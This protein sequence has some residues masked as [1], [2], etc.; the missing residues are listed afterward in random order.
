MVLFKQIKLGTTEEVKTVLL[1]ISS[2][3]PFLAWVVLCRF[4]NH[5]TVI[6]WTGTIQVGSVG[7][8]WCI[9]F[10]GFS[11]FVHRPDSKELE[12]K[13][14]TFQ[15]L[16]LPSPLDGNRSSFRNVVF[17]SSDSL[18][19]GW[20]MNCKELYSIVM[21]LLLHIQTSWIKMSSAILIILR[22]FVVLISPCQW[23]IQT[24]HDHFP[25]FPH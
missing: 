10:N 6:M 4:W 9:W 15:K 20:R 5:L 8:W 7:F 2:Q 12:D 14:T 18:E 17:L 19:S 25:L 16:D 3:L 24:G 1:Y 23:N 13:N 22:F 21:A 11:D